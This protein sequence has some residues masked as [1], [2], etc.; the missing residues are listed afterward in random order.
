MFSTKTIAG[1]F[2][3]PFFIIFVIG[4]VI[5]IANYLFSV[6]NITNDVYNAEAVKLKQFY[7]SQVERKTVVALT[8][9]IALSG[10]HTV[11]DALKKN[12]RQIAINGLQTVINEYQ[13]STDMK[14]VQIHIH[15]KDVHS[16]VRSW[17]LEKFGDDL[18][19]FRQ[20]LVKLAENKKPIAEVEVG[21]AGL[22]LRGMAPVVQNGD[23]LGSIEFIQTFDS[24]A[25][26]GV[27]KHY[28]VAIVV[29][30]AKVEKAE[31]LKTAPKVAADFTL[32]TKADLTTPEFLKQVGTLD[33]TQN[34]PQESDGWL[35]IAI[36]IEDFSDKV[37]GY[38]IIGESLET[39]HTVISQAKQ[40]LQRQTAITILLFIV[41]LA[42]LIVLMKA[43]VT[44]P[45][46]E[47]DDMLGELANSDADLRKRLP[48][49]TQ[50][51][52]GSAIIS[53]NK[54]LNKVEVVANDAKEHLLS[55][56]AAQKESRHG[57]E[58]NEMFVQLTHKMLGGTQFSVQ[59]LQ[60]SMTHNIESLNKVNEINSQNQSVI[61]DVKLS[62]N[63]IA[64]SLS[65]IVLMINQNRT[66][67]EDLE[68]S[69]SAIS[70]VIAL[71]KDISDQT[72]LL[73]LNAAIE[74]ARAGEHGRGFAVVADEVRKLAE[75][76]QKATTEVEMNINLLKQNASA[77]VENSEK[78]E[79]KANTGSK[80]LDDFRDSLEKLI[81]NAH[82]A[83]HD[84]QE[85]AFGTFGGL[86]K[87][88]H[89]VFKINAYASI[90]EGKKAAEFSD[91]H[92]CR[93]GKW[94]EQGDGKK[95]F[96]ATKTYKE[97]DLPHSKVHKAVNDA[98]KYL[99][100]GTYLENKVKVL[101]LFEEAEQESSKLVKLLDTMIQEASQS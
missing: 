61:E 1:K 46:K 31:S 75:R 7:D 85:I 51:E 78:S 28:D 26:A 42:A 20:T 87:L 89:L 40:A 38:A 39:V 70:S 23:Y 35:S 11:V 90:L 55:A 73:A 37:I 5:I 80:L 9:A 53:F 62:T 6:K 98:I 49:K 30:S 76:T 33:F 92:G 86:A 99:E 13:A 93:L 72:N 60:H 18:K 12:D 15:D 50:D 54:F 41:I 4:F 58:L 17:K 43:V 47:L 96:N 94:Y 10:N 8:S 14:K 25:D 68:K 29:N 97:L 19:G 83:R 101:A 63:H 3:I 81:Q 44:V 79:I 95:Y 32:A 24:I 88:D 34:I 16:F 67:S 82:K 91:H 21:V 48:V 59:D 100:N 2:N 57:V 84:N 52:I 56:E 64:D 66:E 36:P 77:L 22:V 27:K 71:I 74:A 65:E 69:V 45:M